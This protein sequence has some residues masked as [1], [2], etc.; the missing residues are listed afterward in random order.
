MTIN[1]KTTNREMVKSSVLRGAV[2]N[3]NNHGI[4][5]TILGVF[6]SPASAAPVGCGPQPLSTVVIKVL[7]EH[8]IIFGVLFSMVII[9]LIY[10]KYFKQYKIE[11]WILFAKHFLS[12]FH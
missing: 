10:L 4:Q 2:N 1:K 5:D 8:P 6:Q 7:L 3:N 12:L 11:R 9:G